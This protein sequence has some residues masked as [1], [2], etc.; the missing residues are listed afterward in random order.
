VGTPIPIDIGYTID[1]D[2]GDPTHVFVTGLAANQGQLVVSTDGAA[3]W[4]SRS[5]PNTDESRPPYLAALHPVDPNRIF[6]RTDAWLSDGTDLVASD[7]LLYSSDGGTT[8]TEVLHAQA[9]LLGFA[10]SPDGS[11]VLVGYGDPQE[12]ASEVAQGPFGVYKANTDQFAFEQIFADPVAC[13][14]W[15]KSGVYVCGSQSVDG[16]ELAFS[17]DANFTLD[18]GC[19]T[20]LLRLDQVRGP[21]ACAAST[22]GSVCAD[23]WPVACVTF[24]SCQDAAASDLR[25]V[26]TEDG[27]GPPADSGSSEAGGTPAARAAAPS[28]GSCALARGGRTSAL[29]LAVLVLSAALVTRRVAS[30][31][32]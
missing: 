22:I 2:P 32:S 23:A 31:C 24:G 6:V 25:C 29:V 8:W 5:I 17:P 13:L 18:S 16:F 26:G 20:P 1:V 11:T 27:A 14:A 15:T 3:T 21:L 12:S 28:G 30:T 10:L 19:L 4:T 7:S 9:K